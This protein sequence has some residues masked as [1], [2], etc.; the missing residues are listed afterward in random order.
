[1]AGTDRHAILFEEDVDVRFS[2]LD[3]YGHVNSKHYIDYVLASRWMFLSRKIKFTIE[4]CLKKGLGFFLIRSEIDYKKNITGRDKVR[5]QSYVSSLGKVRLTVTF[6]IIDCETAKEVFAR[7]QLE[8]AV[9]DMT[10]KRPQSCPD[11]AL[12]L[13]AKKS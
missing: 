7:G 1:M 11:W 13:F 6:E 9:M 8:F 12:D 3:A 4:D 2:D 5:V 10:T